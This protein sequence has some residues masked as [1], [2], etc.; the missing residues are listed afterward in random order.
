MRT[1]HHQLIP[2]KSVFHFVDE[3][4]IIKCLRY[5]STY[6]LLEKRIILFDSI[7][8]KCTNKQVRHFE[9]HTKKQKKEHFLLENPKGFEIFFQEEEK[10][11]PNWNRLT[12][13]HFLEDFIDQTKDN[14]R[15]IKNLKYIYNFI[16]DTEEI[17]ER[18]IFECDLLL[19]MLSDIEGFTEVMIKSYFYLYF[20]IKNSAKKK[21][22]RQ[23]KDMLKDHIISSKI[24]FNQIVSEKTKE[25][26]MI[27][28]F[29]CV[30]T[31]KENYIDSNNFEN[32]ET[33]KP[34]IIMFKQEVHRII[35]EEADYIFTSEIHFGNW[36]LSLLRFMLLI[37]PIPFD[38][39]KHITTFNILLYLAPFPSLPDDEDKKKQFKRSIVKY[40]IYPEQ[41]REKTKTKIMT[42]INK[43]RFFSVHPF[44]RNIFVS[45]LLHLSCS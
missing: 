38:L 22:K 40:T 18:S 8:L 25:K 27:N 1:N 6:F 30:E 21:T 26:I 42:S 17:F 24:V 7:S 2:F 44:I 11:T 45:K 3:N 23:W 16:E 41:A 37:E 19:N 5:L 14:Q 10:T 9:F 34:I 36:F 12:W 33:L 15:Y 20:Q 32:D 29:R 13:F 35:S 39:M 4:C 43:E 28:I 31:L